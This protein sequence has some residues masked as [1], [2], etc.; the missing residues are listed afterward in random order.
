MGTGYDVIVIGAGI[1]GLAAADTLCQAGRRV[2]VLESRARLG[3][4]IHSIPLKDGSGVSGPVDLGASFVHGVRS[5]PL[6]E[7]A[8][9]VPFE[10]HI[11]EDDRATWVAF[12][13]EAAGKAQNE[14]KA[15][16]LVHLSQLI[17]FTRLLSLAQ[18]AADGPPS[19]EASLWSVVQDARPGNGI[20]AGVD[21]AEVAP[22]LEHMK[23]FSG[24]T[25]AD[26][27]DVALQWWGFEQTFIGEDAIV[28]PGYSTLIDWYASRINAAGGKILLDHKVEEIVRAGEDDEG[29][30][31]RVASTED[32]C[33]Q[34]V[35][36]GAYVL[37]SLPLG[38]LQK[39]SPKFL[40]PL[41]QRRTL[42][43]NR[44]GMGLLN[45]IVVTYSSPWWHKTALSPDQPAHYIYIQRSPGEHSRTR[46]KLAKTQTEALAQ[47]QSVSL[48]VHN[49]YPVT[50]VSGLL[51][52]VGTPLANA[53]EL[54]SNEQ[55]AETIHTRLVSALWP[56]SDER[57][58]PC[59]EQVY[60]TRWASD[61]HAFGSYSYYPKQSRG[62][63]G[64]QDM[65]EASNPLW[66]GRLGFC[67]EHTEPNHWA[68]VHGA[69]LS[70][71]REAKR[72]EDLLQEAADA[73]SQ[74]VGITANKSQ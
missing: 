13:A 2:L 23:M 67:G 69:L 18:E 10:L 1:S 40:P 47:L 27:D 35:F 42:A 50:G 62:G 63:G 58:P 49:Q 41:P 71:I 51:F 70:G 3:G 16:K 68:S 52:F 20:F 43:L 11:P 15:M 17:V 26:L 57:P 59:P 74:A 5:N 53:L 36:K 6:S 65:M 25:G 30:E 48:L 31:L 46:D 21:E 19:P 14:E 32:R 28:K 34:S 33:L 7:L 12:D 54:L 39:S 38:V 66:S 29:V 60:V 44:L 4:R 9:Q 24:W 72:V 73:K 64:P 61:P 45:K 56:H 55:V 22:L 37:C 8:K